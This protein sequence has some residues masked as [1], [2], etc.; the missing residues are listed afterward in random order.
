MNLEESLTFNKA[1]QEENVQ[2]KTQ[3]S[4][5]LKLIYGKKSERFISNESATDQMGLFT[6]NLPDP[7]EVITTEAIS[8]ERKKKKQ[9]PGRQVIPSHIPV[10]VRV[11]EPEQDT[12]GMKCIGV[13]V[14]ETL[15]YVPAKLICIQY[16]RP[17]YVASDESS[18]AIIIADLPS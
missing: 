17:K 9:H 12:T 7:I 1:L 11:I 3:L 8:Y 4:T 5:L 6:D 15:D 13:D 14:T 10:E 16:E 2:L 18:N